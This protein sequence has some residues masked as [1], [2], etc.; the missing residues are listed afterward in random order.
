MVQD[1]RDSDALDDEIG[2][3]EMELAIIIR[4]LMRR[5]LCAAERVKRILLDAQIEEGCGRRIE[6]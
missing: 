4:K 2:L 6:M 5:D 1:F 3:I